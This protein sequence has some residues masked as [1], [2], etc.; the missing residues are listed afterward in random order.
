MM[1][2]ASGW[3][4]R[5]LERREGD[6]SFNLPPMSHLG[7][8]NNVHNNSKQDN[9]IQHA[10]CYHYTYSMRCVT[11]Q[12]PS[13]M[14][15]VGEG[16]IRQREQDGSR[17]MTPYR[18][19]RGGKANHPGKPNDLREEPEGL[20]SMTP[21]RGVRIGEAR[22]QEGQGGCKEKDAT[23]GMSLEPLAQR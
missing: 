18:G 20:R 2:L 9:D 21:T 12:E 15:D 8:N 16:K 13:L 6:D 17:S 11:I 14:T 1:A 22:H 4:V 5:A 23:T 10:C 7:I 3:Q 19:V